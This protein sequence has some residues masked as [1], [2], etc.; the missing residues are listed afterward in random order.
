MAAIISLVGWEKFQ[1]YRDRDPPWVKLYRDLLTSESWV[2]GTDT[3]RLVQVASV[4]L[5]ARYG[6]KIPFDWKLIRKVASLD[7]EREEF[8]EAIAH[9]S[10][11]GFLEIHEV[12]D[13]EPRPEQ[14]ASSVLA[15]C[16]SEKSRAEGEKR[17]S[18]EDRTAAEPPENSPK[19]RKKNKPPEPEWFAQ[20]RMLY[21]PRS[22]DQPIPAALRAA[23][24]RL[25][26]GHTPDDFLAGARRYA[27]FCAA[28]GKIGTEYVQ[29]WAR[30]LGPGKP[31]LQP[32][33]PPATKADARLASNLSAAEEF[34]RRTETTQ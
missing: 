2:L 20:F 6:N 26:E 34:M 3:S 29:Q 7:C 30:F 22:G 24:A 16:S 17:Q 5:A 11:Y 9:L 13:A 12:T 33:T 27:E 18:R 8:G 19:P 23:N 15:K 21:P 32:W 31:F 14:D 4:L 28:T 25:S 10:K 1:H